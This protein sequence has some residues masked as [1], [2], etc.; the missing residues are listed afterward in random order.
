[1]EKLH[2]LLKQ[3]ED[4]MKEENEELKESLEGQGAEDDLVE[5]VEAYEKQLAKLLRAQRDYYIA[6][7]E[8]QVIK[9]ADS[10]KALL[11]YLIA[12]SFQKD[13]FQ[14]EMEEF[15]KEFLTSSMTALAA[16]HM[17]IIDKDIGFDTLSPRTTKWIN[18]WS[19]ELSEL[20]QLQTH[21]DIEKILNKGIEEGKSIPDI[22]KELKDL[23]AFNRNRARVTAITEI[24]TA[25]SASQF[26][27]YQQSPA[28]VA[29]VWKHS[30]AAAI[31]PR[32]HHMDYDG[33]E[34][35]VDEPFIIGGE[36]AMFPR[37]PNL[38]AKER[39]MCHCAMGPVTDS[40]IL[41]LTP[42]EKKKLRDEALESLE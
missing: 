11:A 12:N 26:E 10:L 29:K 14:E 19:K 21:T 13:E 7:I 35:P 39:V 2:L 4:I 15:H 41:G 22:V 24:L 33:T 25:N 18:S 32:P 27:A 1:M 17:D 40:K 6:E 23:P 5:L 37:D 34:V 36:E 28:V 31:N 16:V 20:M 3:L 42:E 9:D 30:G 8:S 38:S